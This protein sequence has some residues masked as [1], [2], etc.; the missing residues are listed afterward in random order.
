MAPALTF[1]PKC[2]ED[3]QKNLG[4]YTLSTL[5][6]GEGQKSL[7]LKHL[8][9]HLSTESLDMLYIFLALV[10]VPMVHFHNPVTSNLVQM[11][12]TI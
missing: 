10:F 8:R 9:N 3:A 5:V 7:H 2:P 11:M 12:G 1:S 4:C 6:F